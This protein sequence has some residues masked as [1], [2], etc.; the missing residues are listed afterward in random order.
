M[1]TYL[2]SPIPIQ[3]G[4]VILSI[5][6]VLVFPP[7]ITFGNGCCGNVNPA[8]SAGPGTMLIGK[9]EPSRSLRSRE[10]VLVGC[11]NSG[12]RTDALNRFCHDQP[13]PRNL[14]GADGC[15]YDLVII[16]A[17]DWHCQ[18]ITGQYQ[19]RYTSAF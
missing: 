2:L 12:S 10:A 9:P 3:A 18:R 14:R 13:I 16:F 11:D 19:P 17:F 5:P 4:L 15:T 7:N 8:G 6:S 1:M